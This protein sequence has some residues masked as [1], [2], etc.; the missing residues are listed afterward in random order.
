MKLSDKIIKSRKN[1]GIT[2]KELAKRCNLSESA[3][4]YYE[5]GKRK[6]IYDVFLRIVKALGYDI[7]KFIVDLEEEKQCQ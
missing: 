1:L 6:P 7:E 5:T 3:I 4:C 2:Q